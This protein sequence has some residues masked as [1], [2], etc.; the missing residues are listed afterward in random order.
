LVKVLGT[1]LDEQVQREDCTYLTASGKTA[2][3]GN[4]LR[5]AIADLHDVKCNSYIF[6]NKASLACVPG[7]PDTPSS[8][9]T[10]AKRFPSTNLR[11]TRLGQ[12]LG[13][14]KSLKEL[15]VTAHRIGDNGAAALGQALVTNSC[16]ERLELSFNPGMSQNG[17][18]P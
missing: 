13:I 3:A 2:K 7:L 15:Y 16:L 6:V 12:A 11:A 4:V 1:I 17:L 18:P 9:P 14:N 5:I 8:S 10:A